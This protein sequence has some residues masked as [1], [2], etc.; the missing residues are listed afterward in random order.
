MGG[1]QDI[2]SKVQ[3]ELDSVVGEYS[4]HWVTLCIFLGR[5]RM[6]NNP[7]PAQNDE[8]INT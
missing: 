7:G 1:Y 6:L 8:I 3:A 5:V 2:Q 4:I